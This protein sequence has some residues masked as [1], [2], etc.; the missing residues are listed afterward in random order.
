MTPSQEVTSMELRTN[1]QS[2][3]GGV[4]SAML[5]DLD[6]GRT[7][8]GGTAL[9]WIALMLVAAAVPAGAALVLMGSVALAVV[10]GLITAGGVGLAAL[11]I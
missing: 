5:Q 2:S 11:M 1:P 8:S 7:D 9:W 6:F 3:P 4:R 10:T